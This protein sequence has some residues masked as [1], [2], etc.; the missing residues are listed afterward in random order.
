MTSS[1]GCCLVFSQTWLKEGEEHAQDYLR[2]SAEMDDYLKTRSGFV[3]R[4]L[5]RSL[6]DPRHFMH[7]R[8]FSSIEAYERMTA[9][10][11]YQAH[12]TALSRHVDAEAYPAGAPPREYGRI[13]HF[14]SAAQP[15]HPSQPETQSTQP[16][17]STHPPAHPAHPPQPET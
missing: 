1:T 16:A 15:A 6:D 4:E 12:I 9:D 8:V 2:L 13:V 7:L 14:T 10:P 11:V 17:Q 5:V 3:R